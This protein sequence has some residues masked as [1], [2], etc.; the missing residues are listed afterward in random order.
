MV[1][2]NAQRLDD[3]AVLSGENKEPL[4]SLQMHQVGVTLLLF[5][6]TAD[7]VLKLRISRTSDFCFFDI[8][9]ACPAF[10]VPQ[11]DYVVCVS[12]VLPKVMLAPLN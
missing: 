9:E 2:E 3:I 1:V 5:L 11:V 12:R 8:G 10:E 4:E 7:K 6:K